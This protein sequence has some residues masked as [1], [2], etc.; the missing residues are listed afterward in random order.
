MNLK[1]L[2]R[3]LTVG[4]ALTML[5]CFNPVAA[6]DT[7]GKVLM[8]QG[9]V[10]AYTGMGDQRV[11]RNN[12]AIYE[13]DTIET[14]GEGAV[15]VTLADGTQWDI[16]DQSKV[17]VLEYVYTPGG[18]ASQAS[19]KY[20]VHEGLVTYTSGKMGQ[21]GADIAIQM[22]DNTIY[23]EGTI[24]SFMKRQSV[25]VF[26]TLQGATRVV[27]KSRQTIKVKVGQWMVAAAGQ[28]QVA[29]SAGEAVTV[30]QR[31][32]TRTGVTTTAGGD[33][34]VV[35][36]QMVQTIIKVG[37]KVVSRSKTVDKQIIK[38]DSDGTTSTTATA[39]TTSSAGSG[40]SG[41]PV[42][43]L[44]ATTGLGNLYTLIDII[45]GGS[46]GQNF[47]IDTNT[48]GSTLVPISPN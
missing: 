6:Q 8:M 3:T 9:K 37:K 46:T 41:H 19:A 23:P 43:Y 24:I 4:S 40:G 1:S 18:S 28:T 32:F 48:G 25:S 26:N 33:V 13:G 45:T 27:T 44:P 39:T 17:S 2:L 42:G 36:K 21:A 7:I 38:V 11:L 22:D 30:I 16:M 47:I 35:A 15:V 12:A 10:L 5:M 29:R 14:I 34:R 31:V 20:Q